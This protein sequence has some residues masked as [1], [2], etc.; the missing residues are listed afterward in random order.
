M[1]FAT[2]IA[3]IAIVIT[4]FSVFAQTRSD[5]GAALTGSPVAANTDIAAQDMRRFFRTTETCESGGHLIFRTN[6]SCA[7]TDA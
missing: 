6:S 1:R 2:F 7:D 3:L 5:E 4:A